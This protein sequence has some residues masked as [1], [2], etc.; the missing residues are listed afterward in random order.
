M[1]TYVYKFFASYAQILTFAPEKYTN[2]NKKY[3]YQ[4]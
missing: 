1:T 2:N 4:R 3:N